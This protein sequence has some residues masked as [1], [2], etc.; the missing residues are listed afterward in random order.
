MISGVHGKHT[1]A[2]EHVKKLENKMFAC[3]VTPCMLNMTLLPEIMTVHFHYLA[4][5]RL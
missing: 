4:H 5:N 2:T 1:R 3:S